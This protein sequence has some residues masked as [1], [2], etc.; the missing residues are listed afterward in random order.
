[1]FGTG[2]LL[3]VRLGFLLTLLG[4]ARHGTVAI[5]M[6]AF[7]P[8]SVV[9]PRQAGAGE[10]EDALGPCVVVLALLPGAGCGCDHQYPQRCLM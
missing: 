10:F 6:A 8:V 5:E 1:M 9:L 7:A 3:T 2:D 4:H